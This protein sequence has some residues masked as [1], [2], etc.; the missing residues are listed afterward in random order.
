MHAT[1]WDAAAPALVEVEDGAAKVSSLPCLDLPLAVVIEGAHQLLYRDRETDGKERFTRRDIDLP[2][3]VVIKGAH[4]L[5][6]RDR[7]SQM[8]GEG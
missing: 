2:L 6:Y 4:Q 1:A 8:D 7:E 3:E 5:L